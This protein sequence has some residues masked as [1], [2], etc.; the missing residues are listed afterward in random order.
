MLLSHFMKRIFFIIGFLVS[1]L[2][3][4]SGQTWVIQGTIE[5]C[6]NGKIHLTA[7]YGDSFTVVDS[8][9][10]HSGFFYF[11]L[12]DD[13]PTGIYRIIFAERADGIWSQNSFVEF[14]FNRES[15]DIN[16]V[17]TERGP[18][19]YFEGS[20]EN[21]VYSEFMNFELSYE[22]N[23]R[24]VYA[25][26][27][28]RPTGQEDK[29]KVAAHYNAL[30][31]ERMAYMDS[32]TLI[33]P[34]L[35]AV[36]V[37]NAFRSP[38]IPGE[39]KHLQRIDT[40]K[41]CFFDHASIDEPELLY[42][43]VYP[44]KLIDYLSLYKVDSLNRE[45]QEE[46]FMEAVDH[47]MVNVSREEELRSFVVDFLLEGFEML[48]MEQVQIYIAEQYLDE[49]CESDIVELILSRMEANKKMA[50][51]EMAPDILIRDS[52]G[53]NVRLSDLPDAYVLVVF[54]ASTCEHC[55]GMMPELQEWYRSDE[56]FGVEVLSIS[57][58]TSLADF[59]HFVKLQD[60]EWISAFD[61]LGWYGKVSSD[62]H[63]YATPAL[64]LLDK[65]RIILARPTSFR[66]FQRS[67]KKLAP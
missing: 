41:Q 11:M 22:E 61:P 35:Y 3:A 17:S 45:Q 6:E 28:P 43:P 50:P 55:R 64:F 7:F 29:M 5:N 59:E 4:L 63:I 60:P 44:F 26:L 2:Q 14:V 42:A 47:I 30:Q 24:S 49:A 48:D 53:K 1:G 58:D 10:T 32:I 20:L 8:M 54:W 38:L 52:K 33:Y 66:Q 39:M 65:E 25:Q 12:S 18:V 40:L 13:A 21:R 27:Y 46:Q 36:R 23:I 56:N 16:V 15:M 9:D 31:K 37:M 62:Y 51:G 67:V 57:I 34:D 19:P